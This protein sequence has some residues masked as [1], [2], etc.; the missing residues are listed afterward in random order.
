MSG[1][2]IGKYILVTG[3]TGRQGGAVVQNLLKNNLPVRALTR[4]PDSIS[5]QALISKGVHLIKGD[6]G[7]PDSL[8]HAMTDC[9]AVFSIQNF[10]EYGAEPEIRYGK[11][12]ADAAKKTGVSHFVYSS[13]CNAGDHTGVPHFET[14]FIIEKYIQQIGL[15]A[16]ILR[17]VKFMENYYIL[18]VFKGILGGKLFDPINAAKRHQM[19]AAEDI[20]KYAAAVFLNPD[21]SMGLEIELAGD[22]LSND[23]I[24][25]TMSHILGTKIKFRRLPLFVARLMMDREMYLMFKWFN[26]KG[27]SADM[28]RTK[29]HFPSIVPTTLSKWL[30]NENWQRW[31]K[32]G[33]V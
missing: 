32:K 23:Q 3:A 20:G 5:S 13:V 8:I 18:Q 26:E 9:Y 14:K 2:N 27:F 28:E 17:P 22:E 25:D 16:T 12:M 11:N 1:T 31:N 15:P 7:D 10:F 19:I 29:S 24:A 33:T 6:M 30:L 4:S 21:K